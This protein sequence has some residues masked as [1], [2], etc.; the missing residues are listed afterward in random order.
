MFDIEKRQGTSDLEKNKIVKMFSL[1]PFK[2]NKNYFI[3]KI[4][5]LFLVLEKCVK[6]RA[7]SLHA[8]N[9]RFDL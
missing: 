9:P 8:P 6:V 4:K 3:I 5:R 2:L 1:R 7:F